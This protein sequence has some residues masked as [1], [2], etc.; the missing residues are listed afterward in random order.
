MDLKRIDADGAVEVQ[1]PIPSKKADKLVAEYQSKVR[2]EEGEEARV[3]TWKIA[4]RILA[5][6]PRSLLIIMGTL[7][8]LLQD[9]FGV[10]M[11]IAGISLD[12]LWI[13]RRS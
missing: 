8:R 5:N 3:V 12:V 4:I 10:W 9:G 11:I 13:L 1:S 7:L 6:N 2:D